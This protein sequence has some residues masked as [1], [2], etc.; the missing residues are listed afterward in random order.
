VVCSRFNSSAIVL[1]SVRA[2]LGMP[3]G[4]HLYA[5]IKREKL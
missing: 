3:P 5:R 2:S 4:N 1:L